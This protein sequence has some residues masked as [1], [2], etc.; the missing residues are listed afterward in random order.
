M[1][2]HS[3]TLPPSVS[4]AVL[5]PPLSVPVA[6][7]GRAGHKP[8][9]DM[10]E[11]APA[12]SSE[13]YIPNPLKMFDRIVIHPVAWPDEALRWMGVPRSLPTTSLTFTHRLSEASMSASA[14][15]TFDCVADALRG[16]KPVSREDLG[17]L[18]VDAFTSIADAQNVYIYR[19]ARAYLSLG[20]LRVRMEPMHGFSGSGVAPVLAYLDEAYRKL[21]REKL[22]LWRSARAEGEEVRQDDEHVEVMDVATLYAMAQEHKRWGVPADADGNYTVRTLCVLFC[23]GTDTSFRR[24]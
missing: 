17:A 6:A 12:S 2:T 13:A 23:T 1:T 21:R 11:H 8:A 9:Q 24:E 22:V 16:G 18:V 7:Y 14:R 4:T 20:D 15:Q 19:R 10:S 5:A 3:P